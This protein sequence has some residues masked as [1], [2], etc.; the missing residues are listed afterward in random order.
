MGIYET[1]Y[2][3]WDSFGVYMG[4]PGTHPWSQGFPRTDQLP[5]G[6]PMP[7]TIELPPGDLFYPKAWGLPELRDAIAARYRELYGV[8][9]ER[10]ET[11]VTCGGKHAINH[12]AEFRQTRSC[13]K[14]R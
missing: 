12:D 13:F 11:V 14:S 10:A 6:P 8:E 1:L 7:T 2:A 3:F 9:Y 4:G 5:G